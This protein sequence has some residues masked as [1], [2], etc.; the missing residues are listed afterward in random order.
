MFFAPS[1][2]TLFFHVRGLGATIVWQYCL[3]SHSLRE[4]RWVAAVK[5]PEKAVILI[6][7]NFVTHVDD[8]R[9]LKLL[10]P[11]INIHY[12]SA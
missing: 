6:A 5:T 10:H 2:P 8:P 9:R 4:K 7:L 1:F 11:K 3:P 12:A